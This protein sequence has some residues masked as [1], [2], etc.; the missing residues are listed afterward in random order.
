MSVERLL[1]AEADTYRKALVQLWG[2]AT[3][4]N[5]KTLD[6]ADVGRIAG[7]AIDQGNELHRRAKAVAS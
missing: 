6:K 1:R 5:R 3:S 2:N 7:N 4:G